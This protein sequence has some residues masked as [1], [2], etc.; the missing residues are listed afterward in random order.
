[1]P[2]DHEE[3]GRLRAEWADK[4]G[5]TEGLTVTLVNEQPAVVRAI[6]ENRVEL[7]ANHPIAGTVLIFNVTLLGVNEHGVQA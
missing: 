7:D 2:A 6:D 3:I 5:L 4:G 1:M